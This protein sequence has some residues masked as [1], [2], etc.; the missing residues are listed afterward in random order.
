MRA[1]GRYWPVILALL[2]ALSLEIAPLPHTADILRPP[3]LAMSIIYWTMH[4]PGR[5]GVGV[6]WVVGL[7]LDIL[8]GSVL[9][10]HALMLSIAAYLT[11]M[12]RQRMRVFPIW[13][14]TVAVGGIV[15]VYVFLGF[16]ID[17][18]TGEL[19][20]GVLRLAPI[21]SAVLLWPPLSWLTGRLITP[22]ARG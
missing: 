16:W 9:G 4:Q 19:E 17:G 2:I 6:A 22:L 20:G 8:N 3:W 11:I 10:Q 12:F 13:Q 14:Q 18:M 21:L 15:A 5:Y 7:V 1:G